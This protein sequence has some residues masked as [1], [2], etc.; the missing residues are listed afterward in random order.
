MRARRVVEPQVPGEAR[1]GGA[2]TLQPGI[3]GD[4]RSHRQE[5]SDS[6]IDSGRAAQRA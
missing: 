4:A 6:S 3:T 5:P 1:P 2:L